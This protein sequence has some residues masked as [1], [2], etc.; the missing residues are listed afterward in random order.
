MIVGFLGENLLL[1]LGRQGCLVVSLLGTA[2][3]INGFV[4]LTFIFLVLLMRCYLCWIMFLLLFLCFIYSFA[5]FCSVTIPTPPNPWIYINSCSQCNLS[6]HIVLMQTNLYQLM[7]YY[8]WL[9]VL[10]I[11]HLLY[12]SFYGFS[13]RQAFAIIIFYFK[14]PL[15]Y[16]NILDW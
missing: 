9:Y 10:I 6:S 4:W 15:V 3:W 16:L 1:S 12:T 14:A 5:I 2:Q 11:L 8:L 7:I 13:Q